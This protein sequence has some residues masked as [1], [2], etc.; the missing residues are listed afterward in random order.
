MKKCAYF[1]MKN[2]FDDVREKKNSKNKFM[3]I[4]V[5]FKLLN[6]FFFLQNK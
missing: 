3:N 5:I 1:D 2:L 6:F 4:K